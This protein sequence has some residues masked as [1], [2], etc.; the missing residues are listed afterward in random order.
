MSTPNSTA[1]APASEAPA[2]ANLHEARKELAQAKRRHPAGK[3]AAKAPAKKAPA[4]EK[5][6]KAERKVPKKSDQTK[7]RWQAIKAGENAKTGAA[8][9]TVG[10]ITYQIKQSK[11]AWSASFT[12]GGKTTVL[13]DGV[14]RTR[15]YYA[16]IDYHHWGGLPEVKKAGVK[17]AAGE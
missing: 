2:P 9:A 6:E 10:D 17:K 4:A 16:C 12:K 8:Q 15:C 11:G 5:A 13:L 14:P 1:P 3:A 7:L